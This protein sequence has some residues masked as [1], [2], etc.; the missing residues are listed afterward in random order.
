MFEFPVSI[1]RDRWWGSTLLSKWHSDVL[2]P[3]SVWPPLYQP[4][5]IASTVGSCYINISL[6]QLL[7]LQH[8]G[9]SCIVITTRETTSHRYFHRIMLILPILFISSYFGALRVSSLGVVAD[10]ATSIVFV[11]AA[12]SIE[13]VGYRVAVTRAVPSFHLGLSVGNIP[14][15]FSMGTSSFHLPTPVNCRHPS[16]S[17]S[18]GSYA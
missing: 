3:T 16:T 17:R 4:S 8:L 2:L 5:T 7:N 10:A 1:S 14:E 18:T 9:C 6:E 13:V 12:T 15:A 11:I